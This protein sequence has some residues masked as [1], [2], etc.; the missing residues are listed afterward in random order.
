MNDSKI[1]RIFMMPQEFP[2]GEQS[3]CCGPVGQSEDEIQSLRSGIETE[4]GYEVEVMNV[5]NEADVKDYPQIVQLMHSL[6][7]NALP[8]LT[9]SDE[10][11]SIGKCKPQEALLAIREQTE[12]IKS[13]KENEMPTN[14]NSNEA[15]QESLAESS[16]CC[17]SAD[18]GSSCCS[19]GS[20]V[21]SKSWKLL[22]FLVI[23][24]AAGA[25]LARSLMNKS[26][27]TTDQKQQL[28][29][30]IQPDVKSDTPSAINATAKEDVSDKAAPTLWG[31]ELDSLASL[32][33]AAAETDAVFVLLAAEDQQGNQPI[34]KAIE[35]AAKKIQTNGIRVSAFTLKKGAPNYA[36]LVKQF[37]VPSVLAMVKGRGMSGVSGD[38]S[39]AKL[40]QAFVTASRPTSGCCPSGAGASGCP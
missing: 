18:G 26:D 6:G 32:N 29:A 19:P 24:V 5:K 34:T 3:S 23:V 36:Q 21:G 20:D 27:S 38:I 2:C 35:A 33:K 31:P 11:V 10:V 22:I 14:N 9:L 25:V 17:P 8:I 16:A 1:L 7:P 15:G 30:T 13:G 39:E 4:L 28:F 40:V 12:K 37:S